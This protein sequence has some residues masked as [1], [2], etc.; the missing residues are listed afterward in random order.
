MTH[1][2]I[3][4]KKKALNIHDNVSFNIQKCCDYANKLQQKTV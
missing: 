3:K 4:K 2:I 1:V